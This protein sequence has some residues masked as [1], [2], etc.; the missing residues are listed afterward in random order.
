MQAGE[1]T[2]FVYRCVV[3][4][5]HTPSFHHCSYSEAEGS[6]RLGMRLEGEAGN[7][8]GGE[9]LGMRLEGEGWE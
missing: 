9:R 5:L 7:E 2:P 6:E 1:S 4:S 8:T 3:F